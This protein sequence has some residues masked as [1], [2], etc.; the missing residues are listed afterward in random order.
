MEAGYLLWLL[1][2]I[3]QNDNNK[4]HFKYWSVSYCNSESDNCN[5]A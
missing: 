4:L 1:W 5:L 2:D 3:S